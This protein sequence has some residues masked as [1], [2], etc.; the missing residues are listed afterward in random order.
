MTRHTEVLQI[1]FM[2]PGAGHRRRHWGMSTTAPPTPPPQTTKITHTKRKQDAYP[3][4]GAAASRRDRLA[5]CGHSYTI[6]HIPRTHTPRKY[7]HHLA[8]TNAPPGYLP[9]GAG[10]ARPSPAA[11]Q[12]RNTHAAA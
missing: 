1:Y 4:A 3:P 2:Q 7:H 5:T 12:P 11:A 10:A 8:T 6:K 9:A